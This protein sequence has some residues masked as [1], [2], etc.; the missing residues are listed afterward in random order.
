MEKFDKVLI[1]SFECKPL[2]KYF[3]DKQNNIIF[4]CGLKG[5]EN[6]KTNG[7]EPSYAGFKKSDVFVF[8]KCLFEEI[9]EAYNKNEINKLDSLWGKAKPYC[10]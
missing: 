10:D 6:W 4:T 8:D 3:W 1:N 5:K 2:C 7:I 9:M